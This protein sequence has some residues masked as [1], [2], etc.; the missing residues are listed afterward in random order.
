MSRLQ[1]IL[2]STRPGRVGLPVF[3]WFLERAERHGASSSTRS[4]WRSSA[5]R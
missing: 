4:T 3:T 1:V 5:C 2:A